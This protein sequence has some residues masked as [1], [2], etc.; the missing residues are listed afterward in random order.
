MVR[1]PEIYLKAD[2][3]FLERVQTN[4]GF[5]KAYEIDSLNDPYLLGTEL[6][7]PPFSFDLVDL[8]EYTVIPSS[9]IYPAGYPVLPYV[10]GRLLTVSATLKSFYGTVTQLAKAEQYY[11]ALS[12]AGAAS[13][14]MY[15]IYCD[16][17]NAYLYR[18]GI[19]ISAEYLQETAW[20]EGNPMLVFNENNVWYP[21]MGRDDTT[22]DTTLQNIVAQYATNTTDPELTD[23]EAA[24]V[25]R[26]AAVTAL[27]TGQVKI[28]MI[29][30]ARDWDKWISTS[31]NQP[32][33]MIWEG[34]GIE[35][36]VSVAN[37]NSRIAIVDFLVANA[38]QLSPITAYL[39]AITEEYEG[40]AKIQ[41]L[42]VE[43]L[44]HAS[45]PESGGTYAHGHIWMCGIME[46]NIEGAYYAK[47]G[48]CTS[49][50]ANVKAALDIM[51][52]ESYWM[53]AVCAGPPLYGHS[54]IYVPEYDLAVDLGKVAI[55]NQKSV[56]SYESDRARSCITYLVY[57]DAWASF[58][59]IEEYCGT[60][61]P[62]VAI[63]I[64][65]YLSSIHGD[66]IQGVTYGYV[67]ISSAMFFDHLRNHDKTW[68]AVIL[69]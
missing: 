45:S 59:E 53:H 47:A 46:P 8:A 66:E 48:C 14:H 54:H 1:H 20:I 16:N 12:E 22:E 52:I 6:T 41:N 65:E 9:A 50:A 34:A 64:I 35:G 42:C 39:A 17:E 11:F 38:N 26:F 60:L 58:M 10:D 32:F 18:E 49:Q 29:A 7:G 55:Q 56:L 57:K 23:Y 5:K 21:L 25:S 2:A 40:E 19:T 63:D 51:G 37:G 3:L 33:C 24:L 44:R 36:T 15:L 61:S 13:D 62:A 31:D 4:P 67:P 69:P 43:Y 68:M 28:A 30:A 27:E